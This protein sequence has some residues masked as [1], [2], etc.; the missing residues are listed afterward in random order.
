MLVDTFNRSRL[1]ERFLEDVRTG[2]VTLLGRT[3]LVSSGD[4]FSPFGLMESVR[5]MTNVLQFIDEHSERVILVKTAQEIERAK[6]TNTA[7]LYLYF[8]SPE[9]LEKGALAI[10]TLS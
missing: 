9:P 2:G 1:D 4:V 3:I 7:G 6:A 5:D 8:Q 10:A